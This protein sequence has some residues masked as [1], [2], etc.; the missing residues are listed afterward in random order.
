[1]NVIQIFSTP[2]WESEYPNFA[3]DKE[4]FLECVKLFR[5]SNPESSHKSNINSYQSPINLTTEPDMSPLFEFI[6]QMAQKAAFDMQFVNCDIYLTSAWV[7]F[8]DSRN[9]YNCEHVH[10]DTFSGVFYLQIPERSGRLT[11]V[12][13]GLNPLWQGTMLID[14]KNKFNAERLSID[15]REGQILLWPAYLPHAVETNDHDETRIS[16]AF[17]VICIPKEY[18][19]HTK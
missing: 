19:P 18:V 2:I 17:N 10:Q 3:K 11:L 16:I 9:S 12:N 13:P 8:N 15:P 6:A 7:N 14:Q 1:M 5:E 4:Q